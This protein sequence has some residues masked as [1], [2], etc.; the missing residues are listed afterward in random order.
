MKNR[1]LNKI[2]HITRPYRWLLKRKS[3]KLK[4]Q[5]LP[6]AGNYV[7]TLA[8]VCVKKSEYA[9]MAIQNINSLHYLNSNYKFVIYC[10]NICANA[11]Q[12]NK[13]KFDYIENVEI[14]N[15]FGEA[16]KPW[17]HYKLETII[18]ISKKGW[19]LVD[20]DAFWHDEPR[21]DKE[22]ITFL[23]SEK[24]VRDEEGNSA[25][26]THLFGK[27]EWLDFGYYSSG[28]LSI[29]AKFMTESVIGTARKFLQILLYNDYSFI[30][31][32]EERGQQKRQSEQFAISLAL[33]THYLE[34]LFTTLKATDDV[35]NKHI[36]QSLYY[37]CEHGI[38]E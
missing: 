19:L 22:K 7:H 18:E 25:T 27:E 21:I 20:A 30:G 13:Q 28:F 17:Q 24:K 2:I 31:S 5:F 38:I 15:A 12:S 23:V 11:L 3:K 16:D 29:P 34:T 26:V 1:F 10:D 4:R 8:I 33:L 37:G 9:D 6:H 32:V 36:L 35:K 14:K